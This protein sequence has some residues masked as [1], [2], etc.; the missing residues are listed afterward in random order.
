MLRAALLDGDGVLANSEGIYQ[1]AV[2]KALEPYGIVIGD[3]EYAQRWIIDGTGTVGVMRDYELANRG[4]RLDELR[5][6]RDEILYGLIDGELESIE[7][8]GKLVDMLQGMCPLGLV[9]MDRRECVKRKQEKAGFWDIF[10]VRVTLDDV[11]KN[12]PD[13]E[14]YQLGVEQMRVIVPDLMPQEVLVVEDNPSG[15]KSAKGVKPGGCRVIAYPNNFTKDME[16]PGADR[17]VY[18][19]AKINEEM[20]LSLFPD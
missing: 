3:D 1:R 5:K 17:I 2:N 7:H 4:A 6:I 16:F 18:S 12:K 15:V 14:C 19:L 20:L 10:K 11:R 9:S 13:P 8:A